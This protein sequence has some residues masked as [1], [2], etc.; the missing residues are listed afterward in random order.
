MR[1][2]RMG[3]RRGPFVGNAGDLPKFAANRKSLCTQANLCY[4][5]TMHQALWVRSLLL[6]I[7]LLASSVVFAYHI[8]THITIDVSTCEWSGCQSQPLTG[9]LPSS[10]DRCTEFQAAPPPLPAESTLTI[11]APASGYQSRAPPLSQPVC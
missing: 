4:R 7:L 11:Q 3:A 1:R 5:L 2:F 10:A 9:P 6:A 8:T